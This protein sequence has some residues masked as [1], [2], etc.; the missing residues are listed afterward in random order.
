MQPGLQGCAWGEGSLGRATGPPAP[1]GWSKGSWEQGAA[2]SKWPL[3]A[4]AEGRR[5]ARLVTKGMHSGWLCINMADGTS[6]K[7]PC[8]PVLATGMVN[9]DQPYASGVCK[10]AGSPQLGLFWGSLPVYWYCAPLLL[11]SRAGARWPNWH[12]PCL[13]KH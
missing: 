5:K 2:E 1:A 3:S 6:L 11:H 10:C 8:H 9:F 7:T 4:G 12:C 13:S